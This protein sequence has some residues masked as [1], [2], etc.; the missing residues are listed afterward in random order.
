[1]HKEQQ[2][3]VLLMVVDVDVLFLVVIKEQEINSFVLLMVEGKDVHLKDV[4]N[5]QLVDL[6]YVLLMEV[7]NVVN[8]LVALNLLKLE[9]NIV[10]VMVEVALAV[11]QAVTR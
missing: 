2:S 10:F 8:F 4:V 11:I 1:M 9:R 3:I 5:Q 7:E 6:I